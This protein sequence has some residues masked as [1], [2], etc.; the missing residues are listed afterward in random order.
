MDPEQYDDR[1]YS[2]DE[3]SLEELIAEL[4]PEFAAHAA[5]TASAGPEHIPGEVLGESYEALYR[6][7]GHWVSQAEEIT[8]VPDPDSPWDE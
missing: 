6:N 3:N 1:R 4:F 5:D 2:A 8:N 7:I